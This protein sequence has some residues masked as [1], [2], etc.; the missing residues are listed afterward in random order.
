MDLSGCG[1]TTTTTLSPG[2]STTT[3]LPS[4][5]AGLV[6]IPRALCLLD[7]ALAAPLCGAEPLP[8]KVDTMIRAKL[9]AAHALVAGADQLSDRAHSRRLKR[10]RRALNAAATKARKAAASKNPKKHVSDACAATVQ[11][12]V[13]DIVGAARRRVL[14]ST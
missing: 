11:A 6:G 14:L 1:A 9:E 3:T 5:C 2:G 13:G 12:L 10:A 4:T 8:S 7:T